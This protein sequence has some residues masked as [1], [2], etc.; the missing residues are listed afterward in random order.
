MRGS[1][2]RLFD[3][4]R[5]GIS[6]TGILLFLAGLYWLWSLRDIWPRSTAD[7]VPHHVLESIAVIIV[8]LYLANKGR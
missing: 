4:L 1:H 5:F 3:R 7:P 6:F 8:G 2:S